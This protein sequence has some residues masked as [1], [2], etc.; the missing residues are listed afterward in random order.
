MYVYACVYTCIY[1]VYSTLALEKER[2]IVKEETALRKKQYAVMYMYMCRCT[3]TCISCTSTHVYMYMHE[4]VH[5]NMYM[6]LS[7]HSYRVAGTAESR[8]SPEVVE[9]AGEARSL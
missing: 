2:E 9:D 4:H 6:Y 8:V 7:R 1:M 3:C 5:H